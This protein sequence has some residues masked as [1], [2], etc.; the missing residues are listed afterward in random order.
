MKLV[1]VRC[2]FFLL[3]VDAKGGGTKWHFFYCKWPMMGYQ[4]RS[5]DAKQYL[6]AGCIPS[7]VSCRGLSWTADLGV[8]YD[9][10]CGGLD[11]LYKDDVRHCVVSPMTAHGGGTP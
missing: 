9:A 5:G 7:P 10:A 6:F 1:D 4:V 8:R 11:V 2:W 3:W